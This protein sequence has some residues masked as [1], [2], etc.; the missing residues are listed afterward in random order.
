MRANFRPAR[1]DELRQAQELVIR[2]INDLT[3]RHGFGAMASA[4][5]LDFQLFSLKDDPEGLWVA[6]ADGEML[7]FA[8]SWV[9]DDFWFLAELFVS[10]G[11]QGRKVGRELLMRTFDHARKAGARNKALITFTFNTVSQALYVRHGLFPRIPIYFF[12][13]ARAAL[14]TEHPGEELRVIRLEDTGV[15]RGRLERLDRSTLGFSR[16]KHHAFLLGNAATKGVLLY[17]GD[18]CVG[19]AYVNDAGHIGPVAA[20]RPDAMGAAFRTTLRLAAETEAP[21]VSAFL[22]GVA[23]PALGVAIAR[24]MRMSFPMVLVSEH[25]FGDWTRYLPR[26]PGFM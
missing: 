14:R 7:G 3:E 12:S 16:D 21:Q 22:P 6:E 17:A 15:H 5:P 24:G 13:A 8:F 1:A 10:T 26:N 4:R 23:A 11:Q 2:S 20:A 19:Y 9:S 25:E 18:D